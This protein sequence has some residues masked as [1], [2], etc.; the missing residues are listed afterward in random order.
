MREK[1]SM[2]SGENA[3]INLEKKL[4]IKHWIFFLTFSVTL[5]E[6]ELLKKYCYTKYGLEDN[7]CRNFEN[8][9]VID[10][11]IM[12]FQDESE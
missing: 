3:D 9:L 6:K 2:E 11:R 1:A 12:D 7:L 5:E 10:Q 4:V 8:F